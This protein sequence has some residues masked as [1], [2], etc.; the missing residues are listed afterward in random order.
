[1]IDS[2]LT[3]SYAPSRLVGFPLGPIWSTQA[4]DRSDKHEHWKVPSTGYKASTGDGGQERLA[5]NSAR[6]VTDQCSH[7]VAQRKKPCKRRAS[8]N[9]GLEPIGIGTAKLPLGSRPA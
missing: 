4:F 7:P 6:H 1:V 5:Q 3:L 2:A 8:K 9:W